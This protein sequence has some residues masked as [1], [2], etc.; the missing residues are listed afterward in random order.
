MDPK[1]IVQGSYILKDLKKAL[2]KEAKR[3]KL[4]PTKLASDILERGL[5]RIVSAKAKGASNE[6]QNHPAN[7]ATDGM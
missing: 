3:L 6:N 5:R 1:R 2:D 7:I 4:T